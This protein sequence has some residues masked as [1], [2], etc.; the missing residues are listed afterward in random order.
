MHI[1]LNSSN[2]FSMGSSCSTIFGVLF[3]LRFFSFFLYFSVQ[4]RWKEHMARTTFI[5]ILFE[6]RI[7]EKKNKNDLR[8]HHRQGICW[9]SPFACIFLTVFFIVFTE[10]VLELACFAPSN[11][12]QP[13]TYWKRMHLMF[14]KNHHRQQHLIHGKQTYSA[15]TAD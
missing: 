13:F 3:L 15:Q 11:Q 12:Q 4:W 10:K 5:S 1:S 2:R 6:I 14:C 7:N 8:H 9:L